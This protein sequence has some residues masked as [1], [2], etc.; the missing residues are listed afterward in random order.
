MK[1]NEINRLAP[2][3]DALF[4]NAITNSIKK[5]YKRV[6]HG[7]SL[8]E[9][10]YVLALTEYF[11]EDLSS[12][13]N[14]IFPNHNFTVSSVFCHQKPIV[15]IGYRKKPELGDILFVYS[16]E[17]DNGRVLYNSLLLQAKISNKPTLKIS[18]AEMHQL[19]LYKYWPSFDYGKAN[20][21]NGIVRNIQPKTINNGAQYL[22][23]NDKLLT[24]GVS[25]WPNTVS[26]GCAIPDKTLI[27]DKSL[28]AELVDFLKFKTGRIFEENPRRTDD[29]WTKMIW[30][31]LVMGAFAYNRKNIRKSNEKRGI[32]YS[33]K[34]E[35]S[36]TQIWQELENYV[37]R[38]GNYQLREISNNC[39]S[40]GV[41]IVII[42]NKKIKPDKQ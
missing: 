19:I 31:L 6:P 18:N 25:R 20:F 39:V 7:K 27:L 32:H 23:I 24:G 29:D 42:Q 13:L 4:D 2:V 11:T 40:T 30:D 21:L 15:N 14:T 22:L 41:S 34:K 35:F 9:P 10:D 5:V 12:L 38:F 33:N 16:E 3:L 37:K 17:Q 26:M 8:E 36:D 28:S 1:A